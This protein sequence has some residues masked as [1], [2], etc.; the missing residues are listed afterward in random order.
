LQN[1]LAASYQVTAMISQLTLS[2]YLP[3][4]VS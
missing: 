3:A 2:H 1:Q 4:L